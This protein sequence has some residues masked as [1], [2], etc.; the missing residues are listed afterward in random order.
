MST[1]NPPN[2][3][4][5]TSGLN[6]RVKKPYRPTIGDFMNKAGVD[7]RTAASMLHGVV[8]S[9]QDTR[10]WA[11]IMASDDPL[12]ASRQATYDMYGGVSIQNVDYGPEIIP[13]LVE[14]G[15]AHV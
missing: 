14:I 1:R 2:L 4:P 13:K 5:P 6:T 11:A 8:G 10:D 12:T 3:N 9:N 15:R 7:F